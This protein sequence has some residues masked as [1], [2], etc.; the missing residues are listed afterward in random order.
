MIGFFKKIIIL[1][2]RRYYECNPTVFN[3]VD[4]IH[5]LACALLLLNTDLY[6]KVN[7]KY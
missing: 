3:S 4:Q 1:H 2:S 6:G 7:T 5:T